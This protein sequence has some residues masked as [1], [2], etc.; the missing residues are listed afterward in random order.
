ML[1]VRHFAKLKVARLQQRGL[2]ITP[3]FDTMVFIQTLSQDRNKMI[4]DAMS[5][6]TT[7][8]VEGCYTPVASEVSFGS[9]INSLYK[10]LYNNPPIRPISDYSHHNTV[11][12]YF[13]FKDK[14][15]HQSASH[16][17]RNYIMD[18]LATNMAHVVDS[19]AKLRDMLIHTL[20]Q[21]QSRLWLD[22][23]K[24]L[25]VVHV[26]NFDR[27]SRATIA[28][29]RRE[30]E[31]IQSLNLLIIDD[32]NHLD[33]GSCYGLPDLA[34]HA[35]GYKRTIYVTPH[36]KGSVCTQECAAI[37]LTEPDRVCSVEQAYRM[38]RKLFF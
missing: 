20:A 18:L 13:G 29:V 22:M 34:S 37:N 32:S 30:I 26:S 23:E 10:R 8:T 11:V 4:N 15:Y 35:T 24:T 14:K 28:D 2:H 7:L 38:V 5:V 31:R 9:V 6:A 21:S 12:A 3:R 33:D 17:V 16:N 1:A 27:S 36:H 19:D 25:F